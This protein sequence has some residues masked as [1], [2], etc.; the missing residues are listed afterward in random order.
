MSQRGEGMGS[1][2]SPPEEET[3]TTTP[4]SNPNPTKILRVE[5]EELPPARRKVGREREQ[6]SPRPNDR[7]TPL[8]QL[9]SDNK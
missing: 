4:P 6:P 9:P 1:E 3:L 8:R 5:R 7:E 2:Y